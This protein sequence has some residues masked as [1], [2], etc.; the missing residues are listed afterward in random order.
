MKNILGNFYFKVFIQAVLTL[1]GFLLLAVQIKLQYFDMGDNPWNA[2]IYGIL[3]SFIISLA[4]CITGSDLLKSLKRFLIT[5]GI[6]V[7]CWVLV[8]GVFMVND[9][10]TGTNFTGG[11]LWFTFDMMGED[12]DATVDIRSIVFFILIIGSII[13]GVIAFI[14]YRDSETKITLII[15]ILSGI[16]VILLYILVLV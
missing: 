15:L 2:R 7:V 4:T 16:I 8:G 10:S 11:N 6:M 5:M 1:V 3:G 14:K 9:A 12:V 13:G